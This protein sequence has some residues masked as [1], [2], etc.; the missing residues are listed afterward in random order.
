MHFG[1]KIKSIPGGL[2]ILGRSYPLVTL[3]LDG[4]WMSWMSIYPL[5]S[6]S[7]DIIENAICWVKAEAYN[8]SIC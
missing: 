4:P 3:D 1:L 6:M 5:L 2:T 7:E 8:W